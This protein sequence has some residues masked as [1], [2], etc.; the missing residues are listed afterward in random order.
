MSNRFAVLL[1]CFLFASSA[2]A[3]TV[4]SM[5]PFQGTVAG[6]DVITIHL[7]QVPPCDPSTCQITVSFGGVLAPSID[8]NEP[9]TLHVTTPQHPHGTVDVTIS[10][11]S[12]SGAASASAGQFTFVDLNSLPIRANYEVVLV[13]IAVQSQPVDGAFGSRWTSELWVHNRSSSVAE[14][15]NGLPGC[16]K[17][18]PF[19]CPNDPFPGLP[20]NTMF[21]LTTLSFP[22]RQAFLYYLQRGHD[23]D[24]T[25]SLRVRDLSRSLDNAGT[26]IPLGRESA[27]STDR[28]ELLNVP[29]EDTSR[30][31]LRIYSIEGGSS[32]TAEVRLLAMDA[33]G[34]LVAKKSVS[35]T[36]TPEFGD[37]HGFDIA[38]GVA[39]IADLRSELGNPPAGRYRIEVAPTSFFQAWALATVTNNTTQLVTAI[40]P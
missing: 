30:T 36:R 37:N 26:E 28:I 19:G 34:T 3:L 33:G 15:F 17:A 12:A 9:D 22:P 10:Y 35:V 25:F 29:I 16:I 18:N 31:S 11:S 5:N 4:I 39:F 23:R 24:V 13:P 21:S 7:E 8:T 20:P 2:G 32:E 27:F 38:P 1:G 6:G 40:A 14:L